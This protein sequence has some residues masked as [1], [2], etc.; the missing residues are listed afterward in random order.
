MQGKSQTA[1]RKKFK[2]INQRYSLTKAI[3]NPK[4][5]VKPRGKFQAAEDKSKPAV[6]PGEEIQAAEHH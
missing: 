5:A 2:R 3:K 1:E 4:P 6:P